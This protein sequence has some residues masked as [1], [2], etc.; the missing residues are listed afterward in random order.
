MLIIS[1]RDCDAF[2]VEAADL[3]ITDE[4]GNRYSVIRSDVVD[5]HVDLDATRDDFLDA[6]AVY[7]LRSGGR[8]P[9]IFDAAR[10]WQA[11]RKQVLD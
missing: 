6:V 4:A 8:S 1:V 3:T 5:Q 10:R 9:A 11:A 7:M 2:Y